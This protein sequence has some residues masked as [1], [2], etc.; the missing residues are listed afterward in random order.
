[1]GP[2]LLGLAKSIY[3]FMKYLFVLNRGIID[4]GKDT[5][6]ITPEAEHEVS[7]IIQPPLPAITW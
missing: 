5:F 4:D 2:L 1:M 6:Y 7:L 3:Y